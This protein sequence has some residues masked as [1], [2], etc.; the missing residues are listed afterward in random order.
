M[1]LVGGRTVYGLALGVLTLDTRFPRAPG[2]V[3]NAATW[4]FPVSYRTVRGAIPER[5]ARPDPDPRLLGPIIDVVRE[6][7]GDGVRAIITTCGFLAAYQR[8][9]AGSVSV[10]VF[11]SPLLQVPMAA[12]CI[13]PDQRVGILTARAV[14]TERHYQGAG[15]RSTDI[16]TVQFAPPESSEFVKTFVGNRPQV[17]TDVLDREVHALADRLMTEHSDVGAIVL[18]CANF[19]PFSQ[20]VR[21]AAGVPVFDLYTLGMYAYL[22]S[23]GTSFDAQLR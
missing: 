16:S 18:E 9:L 19:S 23:T 10:P 8:E 4:P 2:D 21:R 14:L 12:R 5:L 13:R 7:E 17:D 15:W 20:T 1:Q 3:G 22:A 6:L 11:A